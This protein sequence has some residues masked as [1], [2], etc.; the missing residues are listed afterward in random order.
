MSGPTKLT[1]SVDATVIESA[2]R[3]A[4]GQG[5]SV[6]AMFERFV[7]LATADADPRLGPVTQAAAGLFVMPADVDHRDLLTESLLDKHGLG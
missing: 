6:S 5:T 1:L 3:L 4:E 2:K 7:R